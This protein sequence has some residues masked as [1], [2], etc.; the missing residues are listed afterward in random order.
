MKSIATLALAGMFTLFLSGARAAE[1]LIVINDQMELDHVEK[2][3]ESGVIPVKEDVKIPLPEP[4]PLEEGTL[5]AWIRPMNWDGNE[6][7]AIQLLRV[8]GDDC[9]WRIYKYRIDKNEYGLMFLYGRPSPEGERYYTFATTSIRD[10]QAR[11]WYHIAAGWSQKEKVISLYINGERKTSRGVHPDHFPT[12]DLSEL[13]LSAPSRKEDGERSQTA[14]GEIALYKEMLSDEAIATASEKNPLAIP[15][16]LND[17]PAGVATIPRLPRAPKIDGHLSEREWDGAARL[18]GGLTIKE[19]ALALERTY[20]VHAGYDDE[21]L[22]LMIVSP[23]KEMKLRAE[24]KEDGVSRIMSDDAVEIL[25]APHEDQ[26]N[27]YQLGGNSLG[28]IFASHAGDMTWR[29]DWQNAN[30]LFEGFWYSE[31]SIPFKALGMKSAP[32]AGTRWKANFCRD[33]ATDSMALFT[34]WSYTPNSFYSHMGEIVFGEKGTGFQIDV[35]PDELANGTVAGVLKKL[36]ATAEVKAV[37]QLEDGAGVHRRE[38]VPFSPEGVLAF[39]ETLPPGRTTNVMLEVATGGGILLRQPLPVHAE[40]G[41]RLGITPVLADQALHLKA[42]LGPAKGDEKTPLLFSMEDAGKAKVLEV[43]LHHPEAGDLDIRIPATGL[44]EGRYQAFLRRGTEIVA[45]RVYDHVGTA[46]WLQWDRQLKE[47]PKPWTPIVYTP[48]KL[49]FWGREYGLHGDL[50]PSSISAL[51]QPVVNGPMELNLVAGGEKLQ[52]DNAAE[53]KE[54]SAVQGLALHRSRSRDWEVSARVH[55]EFDGLWWVEL[56]LTPLRPDATLNAIDL[57]IPFA[58]E[59]ARLVYAH[60][61]SRSVVQGELTPRSLGPF[62]SNLWIGNDDIGL[63]WFTETSEHWKL[64]DPEKTFQYQPG[65]KGDRLKITLVDQA[66]QPGKPVR[67]LFGVQATPIKPAS[68]TRRAL[69][70]APTLHATFAH[71]WSIDRSVKRYGQSDKEWGFTSPHYTTVAE[72]RREV[73][74]WRDKGREMPWYIAPDIISPQSTEFLLFRDEWKNPHAVY[75]FACVASSFRQFCNREMDDLVRKAGL[76]AIY[77]D[78]AKAYPCGN[79]AHGCGFRGEDGELEL[80]T[81]VLA[82]RRFLRD[83]YTS[84]QDGSEKGAETALILHLSAGLTTVAHGFC[85]IALEG[86]ELQSR[87]IKTPSYFDLYPPAKWRAIFAKSSGVNTMLLPNYGRVG[88]KED[89][90][91]IERNATFMTQALLN[92]TPVWNLWTNAEYV[93][94]ILASLDQL[95]WREPSTR[96]EPYWRQKS[97]RFSG[98]NLK[99]STYRMPGAAVVAVGNFEKQSHSAAVTVDLEALGFEPGAVIFR[100]LLTGE[101]YPSRT[102]DLTIPGE[103][104]TLISIEPTSQTSQL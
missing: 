83:L 72:V 79:H 48:E 6:P 67:Y 86:E 44:P 49:S 70:I 95:G 89:R 88:P 93:N 39:H 84:L 43:N 91:S 3:K 96:F 27:Y 58:P 20:V 37:L 21:R 23:A 60:S 38:E 81:P 68:P 46:D 30:T 41:V 90:L 98:G 35:E 42:N 25:L 10:W 56:E 75:Q 2:L 55:V 53:W 57:T 77:V 71:P 5:T 36:S 32:P 14:Y 76:R 50:L 69:R 92:D 19:P 102:F 8:D 73:E 45:E 63:T 54:K 11:D 65:A 78:C 24:V 31:W 97:V 29:G 59:V 26:S 22:Y 104:F 17:L 101:A 47:V 34:S 1:P 13:I 16:T 94:G 9:R 28:K 51:G 103:N 100:N 61:H 15:A 66:W 80:T 64:R 40:A 99:A 18:L 52:W 12:G 85:D 74:K 82:L 7:A 87:I 4:F 62:Y 33:W